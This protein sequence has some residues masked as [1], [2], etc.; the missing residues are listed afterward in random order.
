MM[1]N[2]IQI[3]FTHKKKLFFTKIIKV[4]VCVAII[5]NV[6]TPVTWYHENLQS[7]KVK[8]ISYWHFVLKEKILKRFFIWNLYF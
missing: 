4:N 8:L 5:I 2:S 3:H 1:H 6:G 7:E